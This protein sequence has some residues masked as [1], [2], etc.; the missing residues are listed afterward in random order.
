LEREVSCFVCDLAS[1]TTAVW[2]FRMRVR[3]NKVTT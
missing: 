3:Q 2:A 1:D